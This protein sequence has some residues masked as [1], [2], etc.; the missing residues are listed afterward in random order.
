MNTQVQ[1]LFVN[2]NRMLVKVFLCN[3]ENKITEPGPNMNLKTEKADVE[4]EN[5]FI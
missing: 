1:N 3:G 2:W 5:D 4:S